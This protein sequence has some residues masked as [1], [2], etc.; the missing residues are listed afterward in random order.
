MRLL[1][2][3][4][5]FIILFILLLFLP[6]NYF[7]KT[8]NFNYKFVRFFSN[9]FLKLYDFKIIKCG[10]ENKAPSVIVLNHISYWDIL[11]ISSLY[12]GSFVAKDSVKKWPVLGWSA[13]LIKT[14]FVDRSNARNSIEKLNIQAKEILDAGNNIIIFPQGTTSEYLDKP[15]KGGAFGLA[16]NLNCPIKPV[17]IY[18]EAATDIKWV[19]DDT[20]LAHLFR[21]TKLKKINTYVFELE[22]IYA[23]K[24]EVKDLKIKTQ[25]LLLNKLEEI[26]KIFADKNIATN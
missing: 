26:N 2:F 22:H 19:G 25:G 9:I 4:L 12:D 23:N 8:K 13:T 14:I 3:F 5:V 17:A 10:F 20:L 18:Y 24:L 11:V 21:I 7:V 16:K 6:V 1:K 15:F